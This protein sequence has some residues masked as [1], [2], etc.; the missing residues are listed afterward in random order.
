MNA[1]ALPPAPFGPPLAAT[2]DAL[3]RALLEDF[4][5][6]NSELVNLKRELMRGNVE[7]HDS[8]ER[9]RLL[10]VE[11]EDR[12]RART[13]E[14][15]AARVE[16]DRANDAKSAFLAMMCHELRTP[17]NG[18]VGMID[19]LHE[20][21]LTYGQVEMVDLIRRSALAQLTILEDLL[22]VAKGEAGTV[23]LESVSMQLGQLV[24]AVCTQLEPN[25]VDRGLS[26]SVSVDPDIPLALLGDPR[27]LRQVLFNL[28]GNAIKFSGGGAAPGRVSV[29]AVLAARQPTAAS[30][31]LIIADHGIGMSADTVEQ[32]FSPFS[33]ADASITRRYGGT[34]I[35]LAISNMLVRLMGGTLSVQSVHGQGS[36]FTARLCLA[37][38]A[39][40]V[41]AG[42]IGP[43]A[44]RAAI[45][46]VAATSVPSR[47]EAR[48]QGRLVLVAED[49]DV[50]RKVIARQ[51]ALIGFA[52][53]MAIDGRDALEKWRNDDFALLLTDLHMPEMDGFALAEAIRADENGGQRKPIIALTANSLR[54]E[55]SRC[56]AAGMD[57]CL[58]KPVKLPQLKAALEAG[59]AGNPVS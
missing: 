32:L 6:L 1:G 58:T 27:R 49:N 37:L 55:A 52:I 41:P 31:D 56:V 14:L 33:Q 11:L 36:T 4:S 51:M 18:V 46:F 7:L 21:G 30:I 59:L 39:P 45:P 3:D 26:I 5:R 29:R 44:A 15:Q 48:R 53:E 19:V 38:A 13:A 9:Y 24:H 50:N 17:M 42:G 22:D 16:A 54:N 40:A 20:S 43:V 23:E 12:V 8:A 35:G 2:P 57:N 34:G 25:A 28:I 10:N 47:D